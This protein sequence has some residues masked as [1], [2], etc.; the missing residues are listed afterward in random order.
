MRP[1]MLIGIVLIVFGI[2]ALL[3]QGITYYTTE[4][5]AELGRRGPG[6][7]QAGGGEHLEHGDQ[8]GRQDDDGP[9]APV[10]HGFVLGGELREGQGRPEKGRPCRW[11]CRGLG[12]A[13][14]GAV[15]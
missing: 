14:V 2:A 5:V 10:A 1:L 11:G 9:G 7:G 3:V 15:R 4:R 13:G 12:R 8:D 6:S